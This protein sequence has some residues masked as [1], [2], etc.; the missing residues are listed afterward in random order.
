MLIR[1]TFAWN[2]YANV[3]R[4]CKIHILLMRVIRI[5]LVCA[6]IGSIVAPR[7][8]LAVSPSVAE[9]SKYLAV[10]MRQGGS[11][12]FDTGSSN[13]LGADR[14]FLSGTDPNTHSTFATRWASA[15]ASVGSQPPTEEPLGGQPDGVPTGAATVFQGI[16]WTGNVALTNDTGTFALSKIQVFGD[17]GVQAENSSPVQSV[18]D[19]DFFPDQELT[20]NDGATP[21]SQDKDDLDDPSAPGSDGGIHMNDGLEGDV[22]LSQLVTDLG[23]WRTYIRDTLDG[24]DTPDLMANP[25]CKITADILSTGSTPFDRNYDVCDTDGD[26]VAVIDI[27]RGGSD[28]KLDNAD[29]IIDGDGS[30]FFIFRIVGGSNMLLSNSSILLGDSGIGVDG[31]RPSVSKMGALFVKLPSGSGFTGEPSG[32]SDQVFS[33]SNVVLNGIGLWDLVDINNENSSDTELNMSN[34]Q[35]CAQFISNKVNF[36][37][38]RWT[39][40][41]LAEELTYV[42]LA[43]LVATANASGTTVSWTTA[44][45]IDN[46]GFNIYRSN[47]SDGPWVK[48]NDAL[49]L[50]EGSPFSSTSYTFTDSADAAYYMLEDVDINGFSTPHPPVTVN[51]SATGLGGSTSVVFIPFAH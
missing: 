2:H 40:C 51:E 46:A 24:T 31:S 38:V 12:A 14:S 25:H 3:L 49:I 33:G 32:S 43:S 17:L 48:V 47:S 45:E 4:K 30:V 37:N 22:D 29:W 16:D 44:A 23:L 27:D 20:A 15:G 21:G 10:A 5:W 42:S 1:T 41:A 35:G 11:D 19:S 6:L 18:S 39:R 13:E 9:I 7:P 28:F 8:V 50:A 34:G 26:G 36:S